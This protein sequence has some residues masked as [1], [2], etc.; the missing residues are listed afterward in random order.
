MRPVLA[1]IV[2][3]MTTFGLGAQAAQMVVRGGEHE[4]FTRLVFEAGPE[5]TWELKRSGSVATL[6]LGGPGGEFDLSQAF[7][8]ISRQRIAALTH[9]PGALRIE[10][11][12]DCEVSV[13]R[14]G[15]ALVAL[16]IKDALSKPS[17]ADS[18]N[19]EDKPP[20]A[21]I[22]LT[23][24]DFRDIWVRDFLSRQLEAEIA[25]T[26][27]QKETIPEAQPLADISRQN[28]QKIE[29]IR[30]LEAD[31]A[32]RDF[33]SAP[34]AA[35]VLQ[36]P[37]PSESELAFLHGELAADPIERLAT[38]RRDAFTVTGRVDASAAFDLVEYYAAL[39]LGQEALRL[40][41]LFR[42]SGRRSDVVRAV[43]R[44]MAE[45]EPEKDFWSSGIDCGGQVGFWAFVATDDVDGMSF[46]PDGANAIIRI[47]SGLSPHLQTITGEIAAARMKRHGQDAIAARILELSERATGSQEPQEEVY[48]NV[49]D[50]SDPNPTPIADLSR[51]VQ[52]VDILRMAESY[53]N[54]QQPM[55]RA[56]HDLLASHVFERRGLAEDTEVI[57]A[58]VRAELLSG[59][60]DAA[61]DLLGRIPRDS[62]TEIISD[63][64]SVVLNVPSDPDFLVATRQIAFGNWKERGV[65]LLPL[66]QRAADLGFPQLASDLVT[67]FSNGLS[68]APIS[69]H[70]PEPPA[71][72][73]WKPVEDPMGPTEKSPQLTLENIRALLVQTATLRQDFEDLSIKSL[74]GT[75]P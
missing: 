59:N 65:D 16:D 31:E 54:I 57:H 64:L 15:S 63:F 32:P 49:L 33:R 26:Y 75:R 47:F 17:V 53:W 11:A 7:A 72:S 69:D 5:L 46:G 51:P 22:P 23:R 60:L 40:A 19:I 28:F 44:F 62:D 21:A 52:I 1:A 20:D 43:A 61:H 73:G 29:N 35:P 42:L 10:L 37:C 41:D 70:V 25:R 71:Q 27:E 48:A 74:A 6:V 14:A 2:L 3:L 68:A 39:G 24:I 56:H 45:L 4:T 18:G 66:A 34:V 38:L 36:T 58:L 9:S 50:A 67:D 8:R 30:V 13:F 55:P 12:C